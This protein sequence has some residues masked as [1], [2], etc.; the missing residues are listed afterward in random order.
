MGQRHFGKCWDLNFKNPIIGQGN[1]KMF[2]FWSD[3]KISK[4]L[5]NVFLYSETPK[6]C[7]LALWKR[8]NFF[9]KSEFMCF[10]IWKTDNIRI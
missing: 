1:L 10:G 9:I 2:F 6:I 5:N 7:E 8:K 4:I 3:K